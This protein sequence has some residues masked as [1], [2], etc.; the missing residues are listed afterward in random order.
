MPL[1]WNIYKSDLGFIAKFFLHKLSLW[2]LV[3]IVAR[4]LQNLR[5]VDNNKI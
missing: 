1:L 3:K 2:I 5:Y 4:F